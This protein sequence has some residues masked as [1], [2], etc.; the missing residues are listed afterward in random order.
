M[1]MLAVSE[2]ASLRTMTKLE[3]RVACRNCSNALLIAYVRKYREALTPFIGQKIYKTDGTFLAKVAKELP[4][5]PHSNPTI[6]DSGKPRM[7]INAYVHHGAY[8]LTLRITASIPVYFHGNLTS[9]SLE[10]MAWIAN[11]R[12]DTLEGFPDINPD[13]Y[14]TNITA[15]EILAARAEEQAAQ[16]ALRA[17]NAKLLDFGT[18]DA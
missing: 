15:E 11:T 6:D 3:A 14:R 2:T 18:Y 4:K 16:Q 17:A 13:D 12:G 10:G 7:G 8:S 9:V 5:I 1:N